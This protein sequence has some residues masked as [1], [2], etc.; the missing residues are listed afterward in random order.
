MNN[1]MDSESIAKNSTIFPGETD[2]KVTSFNDR[3]APII[4]IIGVGGGGNNAVN[5]MLADKVPGVSFDNINTDYQALKNSPV[6]SKLVLGTGLGAGNKPEVARQ[7]AEESADKIAALLDEDT[8]MVFITAGMGGGTG[9]GASP[10]VARVAREQG[11]LTIG[12]VTLPF[13]FEGRKKIYKALDGAKELSENVDALML[14]NNELLTEI[15]PDLSWDNAFKKA[16]E[17]L[18]NAA[19]SISELISRNSEGD[20]NADFADV[21]T[22]LR[23]GGTA[24]ISS[25][26][27]EG[28]HRMTMAIQDALH[29]PL[30]KDRDVTTAKR[31]LVHVYHSN[32]SEHP[33]QMSESVELRSFMEEIV[34]DVDVIF[35]RSVDDTLG[36]RVKITIIASGFAEKNVIPEKKEKSPTIKE[37]ITGRLT[38]EPIDTK[39]SNEEDV[40]TKIYGQDKINAQNR[41]KARLNF[42]LLE[43]NELDNDIL[44]NFIEKNPTYRRSSNIGFKNQWKELVESLQ[45]GTS[46]KA[47]ESEAETVEPEKHNASGGITI[48]FD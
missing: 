36:D 6:E 28:E 7:Y 46:T 48:N 20:M 25:G 29:S 42:I 31:I 11:K 5:H 16:D 13:L 40:L 30:L 10:I 38:G 19:R 4:K 24:I 41:K 39:D 35:G 15:Y 43:E 33:L 2:D 3:N 45:A 21:D 27:G 12:V 8:K 44:I 1:V 23:N 32:V 26:Y 9:T 37:K 22:T 47:E 34:E 17:T 14:I 18:S